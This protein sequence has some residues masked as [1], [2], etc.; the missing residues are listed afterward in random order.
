MQSHVIAHRFFFSFRLY[1]IIKKKRPNFFPEKI[2]GR[3]TLNISISFYSARKA[4]AAAAE[5]KSFF[6][7][8]LRY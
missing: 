7:P 8:D 1:R 3:V 6:A 2:S 5:R 4:A